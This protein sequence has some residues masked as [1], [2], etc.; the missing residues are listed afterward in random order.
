MEKRRPPPTPRALVAAFALA[1][2]VTTV[3]AP[4]QTGPPGRGAA[5][6]G[7][8]RA[9]GR[10]PAAPVPEL[11]EPVSLA[12]TVVAL[13]GA[14]GALTGN[15][16]AGGARESGRDAGTRRRVTALGG[17]SVVGAV[18]ALIVVS[19]GPPGGSWRRLV[20][21]A[22]GAGVAGAAALLGVLGSRRAHAAE[23]ELEAAEAKAALGATLA[24]EKIETFRALSLSLRRAGTSQ[25]GGGGPADGDAGDAGEFD[26]LI[27]TYAERAKAE[28]AAGA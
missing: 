16:V 20:G 19:L 28:L 12:W 9:S 21:T 17:P 11:P 6:A 10:A 25:R 14:L 23:K 7:D 26:R 27:N 5:P 13:C 8:L 22:L 4:A 18:A 2:A 15:L 3:L 1:L 24:I